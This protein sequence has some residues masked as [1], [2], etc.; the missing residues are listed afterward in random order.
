MNMRIESS[1]D[2]RICYIIQDFIATNPKEHL[3][4]LL[5]AHAFTR[6]DTTSQIHNFGKNSIFGKLKKSSA[7]RKL[8]KMF[9]QT[10]LQLVK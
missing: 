9:N 10:M 5:F 8:P 6:C 4:H 1:K 3:E 2:E 7:R